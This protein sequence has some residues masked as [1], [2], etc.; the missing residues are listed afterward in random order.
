[1]Q[2]TNMTNTKNPGCGCGGGPAVKSGSCNCAG[3]GCSC[4]GGMSCGCGG[5]GCSVCEAPAAAYSRPQFF[6]GQLLTEDDLQSMVE[7]TVAKNRLHNRMLFGEGVACGLGVNVDPCEPKHHLV[8][9]PGYAID[10]CGNDIVVQCETT[11]DVVQLV[12]DLRARM[13]GKD[14]GDPCKQSDEAEAADPRSALL[15]AGKP[16]ANAARPIGAADPNRAIAGDRNPQLP[17][18]PPKLRAR[19]SY[20]LYVVYC[21]QLADPVAPYDG[22]DTCGGGECTHTRIRE[23]YRFELRCATP[24]GCEPPKRR[25]EPNRGFYQSATGRAVRVYESLSKVD[26]NPSMEARNNVIDDVRSLLSGTPGG[27]ETPQVALVNEARGLDL[28][29]QGQA[30]F[31]TIVALLLIGWLRKEDCGSL[32]PECPSCDEDGVQLACFDFESCTISNLCVQGRIQILSPEYFAQLGLAQVWR[33]MRIAACCQPDEFTDVSVVKNTFGAGQIR[34][35][36]RALVGTQA[37]VIARGAAVEAAADPG[38]G[39]VKRNARADQISIEEFGAFLK[40]RMASIDN[41]DVP[42]YRA[43]LLPDLVRG[44]DTSV[45]RAPADQ[46]AVHAELRKQI[47]GLQ[48]EIDKLKKLLDPKTRGKKGTD[49]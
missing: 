8:V 37:A 30:R 18:E 40:A 16:P 35:Q 21:E 7:Y 38:A 41:P 12:R 14:C 36:P 19:T 27:F 2:T 28:G 3:K 20:C 9:R 26:A 23:G 32:L 46:E 44:F 43:T 11:L 49:R 10:C 34:L 13:L 24:S 4:G 1:M 22:T 45:T 5:K 15:A 47:A 17:A 42:E 33:C 48:S 39:A 6:S 31:N 29:R 25:I